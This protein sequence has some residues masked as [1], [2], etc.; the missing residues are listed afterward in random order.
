MKNGFLLYALLIVLFSSSIIAYELNN[1]NHIDEQIENS[2]FLE[3]YSFTVDSAPF[4]KKEYIIV[5]NEEA[6]LSKK[7]IESS[8]AINK[9]KAE[10]ALL[11]KKLANKKIPVLKKTEKASNS[12]LVKASIN[13][14]ESLKQ[15][16][17]IKNYF[18]NEKIYISLDNSIEYLNIS[19]IWNNPE[20]PYTGKGVK[21]AVLDTGIDYTHSS[22]GGCLGPSCKVI[23]GYDYVND[24]TDPIDD[25]GHGTHVASTIAGN[26]PKGL[27]GVAPD[28]EL[29]SMKVLSAEGSGDLYDILLAYD[30]VID[31]NQNGIPFENEDDYVDIVSMSLG[32]GG[33]N[34]D[35]EISLASDEMM[36]KGILMVIAAGNAGPYNYSIG[37]P[38]ASKESLTVGASGNDYGR[39]STIKVDGNEIV[40][41]AGLNSG[42]GYFTGT[43]FDANYGQDF[44]NVPEGAIAL[45]RRGAFTFNEMVI[46]AERNGVQAIIIVNN[47]NVDFSPLIYYGSSVITAGVS[48]DKL[49]LLLSSSE[50]SIEI[51][52][53]EE[54][55]KLIAPFSSRGPTVSSNFTIVKPDVVAPGYY[56]CAASLSQVTD[57]NRCYDGDYVAMP[58]T[59]M[60]TPHV[61]GLAALLK[62]AKPEW[63]SMMLRDAIKSSSRKI[64]ADRNSQGSG[65]I[66]PTELFDFSRSI[67]LNSSLSF[68]PGTNITNQTFI[69]SNPN[70]FEITY[71]LSSDQDSL[72]EYPG[73]LTV[74]ANSET[75]VIISSKLIPD[76]LVIGEISIND[77]LNHTYPVIFTIDPSKFVRVTVKMPNINSD[78]EFFYYFSVLILYNYETGEYLPY[79]A[80]FSEGEA[81]FLFALNPEQEYDV[82]SYV[83][84]YNYNSSNQTENNLIYDYGEQFN[85]IETGNLSDSGITMDFEN[86]EAH[87]ISSEIN[88]LYSSFFSMTNDYEEIPLFGLSHTLQK[89]YTSLEMG[90]N[91]FWY[92]NNVSKNTICISGI[93]ENTNLNIFSIRQDY[94][95]LFLNKLSFQ[96]IPNTYSI[97]DTYE[98][99]DY[100]FFANSD[101]DNLIYPHPSF[102]YMDGNL[103]TLFNVDMIQAINASLPL[104]I[105]SN[106]DE[107][108]FRG[109][110]L[111]VS[112][113]GEELY[114][115][116]HNDGFVITVY[117]KPLFSLPSYR[118]IDGQRSF[119]TSMNLFDNDFNGA[120]SGVYDKYHFKFVEDSVFTFEDVNFISEIYNITP[121]HYQ[122]YTNLLSSSNLGTIT[123]IFPGHFLGVVFQNHNQSS[124]Y[125]QILTANSVLDYHEVHPL[126]LDLYSEMDVSI[127][128]PL[129]HATDFQPY[130]FTQNNHSY[131]ISHKWHTTMNLDDAN[132][133]SLLDVDIEETTLS[134]AIADEDL[135]LV[136]IY[137]DGDLQNPELLG[138]PYSLIP[139]FFY[140]VDFSD[141]FVVIIPE[142]EEWHFIEIYAEDSAGNWFNQSFFVKKNSLSLTTGDLDYDNDFDL[143][144]LSILTD[145]FGSFGDDSDFN[146]L[147][148]LN[149]DLEVNILDIASLINLFD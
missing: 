114:L 109:R 67:I 72:L 35:N 21:V 1:I 39:T 53:S 55:A 112:F 7:G 102:R 47:E 138:S 51:N 63:D 95:D 4:E 99:T 70:D 27:K 11:N 75:E 49:D 86:C 125:T 106:M 37:I 69:I 113:F 57:A 128:F 3:D 127:D 18:E 139:G 79:G 148:D 28:A 20:S 103:L 16:G 17:A 56:V 77:S 96:E 66:N 61:S 87:E 131:N 46:R 83:Y 19:S 119:Y 90:E 92:E 141:Y 43:I 45:V 115:T 10:Q 13:N 9:V 41:S 24:D 73:T 34:P 133:P 6:P 14:L 68:K 146:E 65:L 76:N 91:Y 23:G 81:N 62:E 120:V 149:G 100:L 129:L 82:R 137:V 30:Y 58:G 5:L 140:D 104:K 117:P 64:L 42:T 32:A 89:V 105:H 123:P 71:T 54:F 31:L 98:S 135:S 122:V 144:D 8:K 26:D 132:P 50:V 116:A 25:H 136:N 29:V 126:G 85:F 97:P 101:E 2:F 74:P 110:G 93:P 48:L 88:S 12:F 80:R 111:E 147:A 52:N 145:Y 143:D 22:L 60:A 84:I 121:G 108:S 15:E 78:Y 44:S 107:E 94:N 59:S 134:L 38:G 130:S 124:I 40:S 33:N 118:Y 36:R 142:D